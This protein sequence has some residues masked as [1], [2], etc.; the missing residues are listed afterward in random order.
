MPSSCCI[1][2]NTD[3]GRLFSWLAGINRWRHR[4]FGFEKNQ[5]QLLA[6]VRAQGI[7]DARILEVGCG[8]GYLHQVLLK[9]GASQAV[10]IDLSDGMLD[11]AR[12]EAAKQGLA[13]RCDYRQGDFVQLASELADA[14][15]VILDKVVC[16]YP[17][18]QGLL[19]A[20]LSRCSRTLALTYPQDR[21]TVRLGVRFLSWLM[22]LLH[23]CYQPYLHDPALIR[24]HIQASGLRL[25]HEDQ[26]GNWLTEIYTRC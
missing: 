8:P 20:A 7:A 4:W 25:V 21:T 1:Q 12:T 10:G 5:R 22:G 17:D 2:S 9:A 3:T 18:W 15:V 23:C 6:G 26:S 16:C 24:S 11:I 19:D 13:D 14:D